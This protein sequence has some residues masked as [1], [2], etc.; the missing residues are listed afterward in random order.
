MSYSCIAWMVAL[1]MQQSFWGFL[2]SSHHHVSM[3]LGE[4][5]CVMSSAAQDAPPHTQTKA[6]VGLLFSLDCKDDF[7]E[8]FLSWRD[9][10][11]AGEKSL[12]AGAP[13]YWQKSSSPTCW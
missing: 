9:F 2:E 12:T 4:D 10:L 11:Q 1:K 13:I 5:V 6:T 8:V 3:L 7:P